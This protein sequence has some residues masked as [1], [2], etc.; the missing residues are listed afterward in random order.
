MKNLKLISGLVFLYIANSGCSSSGSMANMYEPNTPYPERKGSDWC[1]ENYSSASVSSRD[2]QSNAKFCDE[3][4]R[5]AFIEA[6]RKQ[7]S[8]G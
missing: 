3:Q 6:Q 5:R 8:N 2:R 1:Q 7:R 4:S